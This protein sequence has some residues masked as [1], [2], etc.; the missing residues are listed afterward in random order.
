MVTNLFFKL[1]HDY[2]RGKV[3]TA[4]TNRILKKKKPKKGKEDAKN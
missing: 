4:N 2:S 3:L 1:L